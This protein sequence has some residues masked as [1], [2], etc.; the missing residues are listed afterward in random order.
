MPVNSYV[1]IIL[2]SIKYVLYVDAILLAKTNEKNQKSFGLQV[3]FL[4]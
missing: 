1:V 4:N 3:L 2:G